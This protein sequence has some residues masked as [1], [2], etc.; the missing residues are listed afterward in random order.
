MA[1][2][3]LLE[4]ALVDVAA[5]VA[6][7]VGDVEGE[8]VATLLGS[9]LQQL[10]VLLLGEVFLKVAVECGAAGEVL[11]VVF[12]MEAE[13][14]QNGER[15]VLDDVEVGVVAVARHEVAVLAVPLGVFDADVLGGDHLAVE[16]DFLG[17]VFLVF[18]LHQ[19]EDGLHEL[20][21]FGAVLDGD[22]HELGSL[23]EAVDADGEVL[24]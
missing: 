6:D 24:A 10:H 21:V 1:F 14:V 15:L 16:H 4:V 20:A 2:G 7:G 17:A 23:D 3:A 22:A 13:L 12:A 19:A 8:V 5:V 9:H 11:D 18:L